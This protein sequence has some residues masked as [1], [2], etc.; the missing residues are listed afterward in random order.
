MHLRPDS[1]HVFQRGTIQMTTEA[2]SIDPADIG[3]RTTGM[4]SKRRWLTRIP[5]APARR[6]AAAMPPRMLRAY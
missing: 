4:S 5:P 3:P 2:A 6:V 1:I